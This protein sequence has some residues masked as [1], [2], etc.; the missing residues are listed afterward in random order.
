MT[1]K[2][3]MARGI[4]IAKQAEDLTKQTPPPVSEMEALSAEWRGYCQKLI[5]LAQAEP[6]KRRNEIL[7]YY[8]DVGAALD[9]PIVHAT[10]GKRRKKK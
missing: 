6:I 4:V 1:I 8:F 9:L 3:I 10:K 7:N 5:E 2:E